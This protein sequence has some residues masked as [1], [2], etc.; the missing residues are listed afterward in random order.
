MSTARNLEPEQ[1]DKKAK[2]IRQEGNVVWAD[3][4]GDKPK[5]LGDNLIRA[6]FGGDQN[7]TIETNREDAVGVILN[8]KIPVSTRVAIKSLCTYPI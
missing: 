2:V 7:A 8:P 6:N 5:P 1:G 3:F 4:G